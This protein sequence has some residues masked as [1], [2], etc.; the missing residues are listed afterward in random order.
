MCIQSITLSLYLA[1]TFTYKEIPFVTSLTTMNISSNVAEINNSNSS[2]KLNLHRR[3][4]ER[5]LATRPPQVHKH[6][7]R[8]RTTAPNRAIE[9]VERNR[10]IN[11]VVVV[12]VS[13]KVAERNNAMLTTLQLTLKLLLPIKSKGNENNEDL[14]TMIRIVGKEGE[15][16]FF[17]TDFLIFNSQLFFFVHQ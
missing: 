14:P 2:S 17:Y 12:V 16:I 3:Q 15:R 7:N 11:V 5:T 10:T 13:Q 9:V 1:N 8:M 4:P 6:P